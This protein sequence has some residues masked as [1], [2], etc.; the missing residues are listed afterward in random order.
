MK[1]L[2]FA[3]LLS[4]AL[5]SCSQKQV[6][7]SEVTDWAT[8]GKYY[9]DLTEVT[10]AKGQGVE[11]FFVP[12]NPPIRIYFQ[13][14]R[15]FV[16]NA[17]NAISGGYSMQDKDKIS[18][19]QMMSTMKACASEEMNRLD[20]KIFMVFQ[21][22]FS[23][24]LSMAQNPVLVL[25]K[26]SGEKLHFRG[27]PTPERLYGSSGEI[28]FLEVAPRTRVCSHPLNPTLPCLQVREVYYNEDGFKTGNSGDF[29]NLYQP[30]EGYV[31]A[32]GVRNILRVKRYPVKNPPADMSNIVY[33]LDLVVES[34]L[35]SP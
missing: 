14:A 1:N 23:Y 13:E 12:G 31:H 32:D 2:I 7:Q 9:W 21:G 26:E 28:I 20:E 11:G 6:P 8:L 34:E 17:C 15:F 16:E 24:S 18:L 3:I 5:V 27:T 33:I 4:L 22:K 30:I 10:D 25:E 29:E 19:G 35:V